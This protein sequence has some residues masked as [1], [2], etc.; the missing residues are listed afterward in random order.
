[1]SIK[2]FFK[3]MEGKT[4]YQEKLDD[5]LLILSRSN[6]EEAISLFKDLKQVF[7]ERMII[8][9][10]QLEAESQIIKDYFNT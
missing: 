10:Q 7:E 8:K 4:E 1:M 3:V 2:R 6:T 5:L 9:E